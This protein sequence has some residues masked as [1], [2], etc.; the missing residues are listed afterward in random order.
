MFGWLRRRRAWPAQSPLIPIASRRLDAIPRCEACG[1]GSVV[2]FNWDHARRSRDAETRR[3]VAALGA[4]RKL[5]SGT[6][7]SCTRCN[8]AWYLHGDRPWMEAVPE[9]RMPIV[10][11][12]NRAPL[13]LPEAV[14]AA[15]DAIGRTPPD[16]YGNGDAYHE[17]PCSVVTASGEELNLAVVSRQRGA[18]VEESRNYRLASEI[19]EVRPSDFA[20]PLDVRIASSRSPELRMGFAPT[21][22]E[23]PDGGLFVLNWATH[24]LDEPGYS[25][26]DARVSDAPLDMSNLPRIAGTRPAVWFI[27]DP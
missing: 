21:P 13:V 15:L 4:P 12:W 24:F 17:T 5:R 10:E 27:A 14:R 7:Y 16:L 19:A 2:G 11:A 6:V 20:L 23:M 9:G 18:P 22:I 1:A 25:A 8:A 26:A 3:R